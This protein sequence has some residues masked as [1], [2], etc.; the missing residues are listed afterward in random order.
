MNSSRDRPSSS[1]SEISLASGEAQ[2]LETACTG[3]GLEVE[4]TA[5][6]TSLEISAL[7][8]Y[9]HRRS[10]GVGEVG[11]VC[12]GRRECAN[13]GAR[14][15]RRP[16]MVTTPPVSHRPP[17]APLV[18]ARNRGTLDVW[19]QERRFSPFF[20]G[21]GTCDSMAHQDQYVD[22]RSM[23]PPSPPPHTPYIIRHCTF[24]QSSALYL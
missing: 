13:S 4:A 3:F 6:C 24:D 8:R 12:R 14:V 21:I 19:M 17:R 7:A 11:V 20:L 23:P 2:K 15:R 9:S 1:D 18:A 16:P 5:S 22:H 10:A